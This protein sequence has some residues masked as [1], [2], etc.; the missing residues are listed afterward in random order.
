MKT[1]KKI[2]RNVSC[3]ANGRSSDFITPSFIFGC[4]Y[5]CSYCTLK[6]H[7]Y[8]TIQIAENVDK[9]LVSIWNHSQKQKWKKL[10]NQCDNKYYVYDIGCNTDISLH[11]KQLNWVK[12]FNNFKANQRA[13]ASFATKHVREEML[14]FNPEGKVRIRFS[15]MPQDLSTILEPNTHSIEQRLMAVDKFKKAEYSVHL[16]F[17]PIVVRDNWLDSY[18]LLFEQVNDLVKTKINTSCECIFLTHNEGLHNRNIELGVK[19]ESLLWT[20]DI[21]EEK[22]SSYGG[23]NIRYKWQIK[24]KYVE[25]FKKLQ[26]KH[27]PWCKI[28]YIF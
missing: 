7:N 4:G 6:R 25:E 8:D 23:K 21:Q 10:P 26:Q 22:I 5:N 3:K 28:R 13:M 1:F 11:W 15:I 24:K 9:I 14:N 19:G 18:K 2:V 17:S 27:I 12:V 16:N 20:P